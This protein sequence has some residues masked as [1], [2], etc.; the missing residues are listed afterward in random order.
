MVCL[1][2]IS[3]AGVSSVVIAGSTTSA[4][5]RGR[6]GGRG[7]GRGIGRGVGRGGGWGRG[8]GRGRGWG[9]GRGYGY[10]FIAPGC[11]YSPRWGRTICP[12]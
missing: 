9:R 12:Y 7:G 4:A 3:V 2:F 1:Y 8:V 10:G 6:G 5:A 11:Y